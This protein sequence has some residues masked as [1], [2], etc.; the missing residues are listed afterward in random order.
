MRQQPVHLGLDPAL[1]LVPRMVGSVG[2][3][4]SGRAGFTVD[5]ER[6]ICGSR[7]VH[8][9]NVEVE[10]VHLAVLMLVKFG[11]V[12]SILSRWRALPF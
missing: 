10:K 12:E 1:K 6:E 4:R 8:D 9:G 7:R 3:I 11:W 2:Q 5:L